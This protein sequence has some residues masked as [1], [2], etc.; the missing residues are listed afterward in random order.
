M[1]QSHQD[2]DD[3]KE[4]LGGQGVGAG[5]CGPNQCLDAAI[6]LGRRHNLGKEAIFS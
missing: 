3:P 4:G 5:H 2:P 1:M 6:P